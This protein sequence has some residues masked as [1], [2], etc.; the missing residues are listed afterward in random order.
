MGTINPIGAGVPSSFED[1]KA[2]TPR[3]SKDYASKDSNLVLTKNVKNSIIPSNLTSS[4]TG[5]LCNVYGSQKCSRSEGTSIGNAKFRSPERFSDYY[6]KE[7]TN[8]NSDDPIG[9]SFIMQNEANGR[10]SSVMSVNSKLDD[11]MRPTGGNES[12]DFKD[13]GTLSDLTS[14][15]K[16]ETQIGDSD[17][18]NSSLSSSDTRDFSIP[19]KHHIVKKRANS[20]SLESLDTSRTKL[21]FAFDGVSSQKYNST[22]T[23]KDNMDAKKLPYSLAID[24][25][26]VKSTYFHDHR[27]LRHFPTVHLIDQE[28]FI[29]MLK[30][31][32][33]TPLPKSDDVFPWLHGI[34]KNN[35]AQLQFL[36]ACGCNYV[37]KSS[38]E[39]A[40]E[41]EE[42]NREAADP[43]PELAMRRTSSTEKYQSSVMDTNSDSDDS[44]DP[45]ASVIPSPYRPATNLV[46]LH[47]PKGIRNLMVIRSCNSHGEVSSEYSDIITESTGLIRST[48][49]AD[50]VLESSQSVTDL[51][52]FLTSLISKVGLILPVSTETIIDDCLLTKLL[53]VFKDMD[54]EFGVSLRN[55]HIQVSKMSNVSDLVVYCFN[56][57]HDRCVNEA[58]CPKPSCFDFSTG[59][60]KCVSL[61]RLL[62]IAQLIYA[63]EHPELQVR[64]SKKDKNTLSLKKSTNID[65]S[66]ITKYHTILICN[67]TQSRL[68]KANLLAIPVMDSQS[69]L[70]APEELC[71]R[72]DLNVFNNW[73]SNYLYRERLEISKMSTATPISTGHVWLGNITDFEC[74]QIRV[75]GNKRIP[76]EQYKLPDN[77]LHCDP[78]NTVVTLTKDQ[79]DPK[80]ITNEE[81]DSNL[82]TLPKTR[83]RLFIHCYEGAKFTN[84]HELKK[85]FMGGKDSIPLTNMHNISQAQID[86]PPSGS[87]TLVDLSE[88]DILNI[89]N[90]C[91][92]CYAYGGSDFPALLYCSDGYTETSLLA[93][94]FVMYAECLSLDDALVKLHKDYGRP[95]FIFKSDYSLLDKLEPILQEFSPVNTKSQYV[96][97]NVEEN[98]FTFEEDA[99]CIKSILLRPRRRNTG[100][101]S[102]RRVG[103]PGHF[104]SRAVG[105]ALVGTRPVPNGRGYNGV[106][107]STNKRSH[108]VQMRDRASRT[109]QFSGKVGTSRV[110][111]VTSS[112]GTR[113]APQMITRN[114]ANSSKEIRAIPLSRNSSSTSLSSFYATPPPHP[115][116]PVMGSFPSQILP[117]MY[118]GSLEHA[119]CLSMLTCLGIEYLVSVGEFVP[120]LD[121]IRYTTSVTNSGCEIITLIPGQRDPET[122]SLCN[123]KQIMLMKNIN[124]D[125]VGTIVTKI[126]D[127]LDFIDT[128]R[129]NSGKVLV[130][131][132][133]GVS[134]SATV[135]IAE[136]MN[137]LMISLPRA[138]MYVRVRRLNVIIQPNLKLMYELFKLEETFIKK[139]KANGNLK[140]RLVISNTPEFLREVDWCVFCREIFNLNRAYIK[141]A[142]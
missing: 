65:Q 138:Y 72:Y 1:K 80:N 123:V 119:S 12:A 38:T 28:E 53:P 109:R 112:I 86:F 99:S 101:G 85:V 34:H 51:S 57:D 102:S 121:N 137:R 92:L 104:G 130:H 88:E 113:P 84:L 20:T 29:D 79:M 45:D 117:Y 116:E 54:P 26:D 95:F 64:K 32:F 142:C 71:S 5:Q 106:N 125:G 108:A 82:I 94:C 134:R 13:I 114:T 8:S 2:S 78:F 14:S 62:R 49:S 103:G 21:D 17:A 91:K 70:K 42:K 105:T 52:A 135:C 107:F 139:R 4:S 30:H 59:D 74:L 111:Y 9:S 76:T 56:E 39:R 93:A 87:L 7:I 98:A 55:F 141:P 136:V 110:G 129:K 37:G 127:T 44:D 58:A 126:N 90:I 18:I 96:F 31:H 69:S 16:N 75:N 66:V 67:P 118:L 48:V 100:F 25:F 24:P 63:K 73:D 6:T 40:S 50:D 132:Q 68:A 27:Y 61:C 19:T 60:C 97:H 43:I 23:A 120:W 89:V 15:I 33:L 83:W 10:S 122:D 140:K 35:Y 11:A 128:C 77:P 41:D 115:L 124:D 22:I 81:L 46:S 47:V 131:C 133:V 36:G 3:S